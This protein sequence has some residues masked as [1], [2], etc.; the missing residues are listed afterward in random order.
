MKLPTRLRILAL[1]LLLSAA[2]GCT[3]AQEQTPRRPDPP[4]LARCLPEEPLAAPA[5]LAEAADDALDRGE[6]ER[7]L[8][9]ADEALR[10]GP[11]L[12]PA[13]A[14]RAEALEALDRIDEARLAWARALAVNPDDPEALLGAAE[15]HVRR[16]S[17]ARDALEAGLEY[18][19]RGA[20]AARARGDRKLAGRLELV[21]GM[22]ENDLGRSHLALPHLDRAAAILT[23][24]PDV[25]YERGVALFE[26][27]RFGDAQRA[28]ERTLSLA[29]NDA[30]TLH[31]LGLLAER[32]G[33]PKRAEALLAQARRLAPREFRP[34]LELP[35]DAFR[36]Q[37][38]A[39]VASLPEP[40]RRAL[41]R[42]PLEVQD[43]PEATDLGGR[44]VP[45][46]RRPA[47]PRDRPLPQE[48]APLR[49]GS[50]GARR[51]GPGHP[52][53]RAR[54]PARRER[55]RPPGPRPG[56]TVR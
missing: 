30:W 11:R 38:G 44:A 13:L 55:R 50:Q 34:E 3:R 54:A 46:L 53:P 48:P 20:R 41:E 42:V 37:V 23:D 52:A 22:A 49:A 36:A 5:R 2:G 40:E 47:L 39:A 31:Q 4:P 51:A 28:F 35:P 32:R 19:L 8:A 29:P 45:P 17:P 14:A 1:P 10:G 21:A 25:S 43:L 6:N 16:L 18:A 33:A 15:L 9:C 26:L 12:V 56:V 27:C 7:A 24:D